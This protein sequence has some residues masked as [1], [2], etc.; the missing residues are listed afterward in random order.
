[1]KK[2]LLILLCLPLLF[3]SCKKED[4]NC[5]DYLGINYG[6]EAPIELYAIKV[7]NDCTN[8]TETFIVDMEI[9]DYILNNNDRYCSGIW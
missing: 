8:N 6:A 1:M 7:R 9:Y 5:G 3:T 2:L 4:C